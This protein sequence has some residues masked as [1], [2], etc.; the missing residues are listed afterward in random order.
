MLTSY[1][2]TFLDL[3]IDFTNKIDISD[4]EDGLYILHFEVDGEKVK[5]RFLKQ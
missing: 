5:R 3:A 4:L 2:Q 1:Q